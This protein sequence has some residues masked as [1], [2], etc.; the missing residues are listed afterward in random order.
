M[1]GDWIFI[2]DAHLTGR[3][4]EEIDI[5]L[6]FLKSHKGRIDHLVILGDLFEFFFGFK[7]S[8]PPPFQDYL[9]ILKELQDLYIQGAQI[10]YIEGNHDFSIHHFFENHFGMKVEVFPEGFETDLAGKRAF[11]SHG[12]LSNPKLWGYRIFRKAL[13]NRFTFRLIELIGPNFSRWIAQKMSQRS[14]RR[15]HGKILQSPPPEFKSFAYQKFIEGFEVVILG[16]SHFPENVE[17]K[18]GGRKCLY[19]N[20]GDWMNHRSYLRFVPPDTF[21][22]KRWEGK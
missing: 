21:E 8:S 15:S 20:V 14:Y 18:V 9:P 5:F 10:K 2:S 17:E 19:F 6:K 1:P 13:K 16:H 3:E 12:D 11:L 22:L 7:K 4:Q